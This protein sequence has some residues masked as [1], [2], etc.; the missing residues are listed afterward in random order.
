MSGICEC[1]ECLY[2]EFYYPDHNLFQKNNYENVFDYIDGSDKIVALNPAA[3]IL[4]VSMERMKLTE[5]DRTVDPEKRDKCQ[6]MV[7]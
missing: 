6:L 4:S 1:D 2:L 3:S 7:V 5:P